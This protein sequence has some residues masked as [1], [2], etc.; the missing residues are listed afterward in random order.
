[1][2]DGK[3]KE[4]FTYVK[5]KKL[6]IAQAVRKSSSVP[7]DFAPIHIICF[8]SS[9][10]CLLVWSFRRQMSK[11]MFVKTFHAGSTDDPVVSLI[12]TGLFH[13]VS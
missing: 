2:V 4:I 3:N 10:W 7:P 12:G 8:H 6:N 13:E 1:M 11:N 9:L 5:L